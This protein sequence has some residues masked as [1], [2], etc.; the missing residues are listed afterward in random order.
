MK[1]KMTLFTKLFTYFG[2]IIAIPS[3]IFAMYVLRTGR[4]ELQKNLREQ[5]E[6]NISTDTNTYAQIIEEYRHKTYEISNNADLV[7]L[8]SSPNK[9]LLETKDVY[10]D[11]FEVMKGDTYKASVNIVSIDGKVRLSTHVFPERYD[12]RYYNTESDST[13]PI[14]WNEPSKQTSVSITN[15]YV[16]DT[17]N[18]TALSFIRNVFDSSSNNIGYVILDVYDVRLANLFNTRNFF[19]EEI[20]INKKK[21]L[22]ASLTD[23]FTYGNFLEFPFLDN[24]PDELVTSTVVKGNYLYSIKEIQ[25]T[26]FVILGTINLSHY[27]DNFYSIAKILTIILILG[28]LIGVLL[29]YLFSRNISNSIKEVINS[30][31]KVEEGNLAIDYRES[32]IKELEELN[33][34]FNY[35]V[36]QLVKLV[37]QVQEDERKASTAE[38]KSLEAQLNPHFLFNTLNTIKALARINGQEEIYEISLKLGTLLRSNLNNKST[39]STVAESI[40]L[41]NDYLTIQKIRF[42]DKL[43]VS[44][45]IDDD[46]CDVVI[47]KLIIQPLVENSLKHGLEPKIGD[48]FIDIKVKQVESRLVIIVTDNGVGLPPD[49]DSNNIRLLGNTTHVGLYNIYRRLDIHY[50]GD[51]SFKIETGDDDLTRAEINLPLTSTIANLN[52]SLDS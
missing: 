19:D 13:N 21:F 45:D 34:N 29:S 31:H 15:R 32:N 35:M 47:P 33:D 3:L 23:S 25:N 18:R 27:N 28:L 22:A 14:T 36:V 16:N 40:S 41:V 8:L 50:N 39:T 37:K 26:D 44:Y 4:V 6:I 1:W 49:F 11:L 17:G 51:M 9:E 2:I 38:L 42:G 24:R 10:S 30:M 46:V 52:T 20:I 12:V 48:W 7:K 43:H 5:A